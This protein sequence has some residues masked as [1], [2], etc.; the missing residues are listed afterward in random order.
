MTN[1]MLATGHREIH[2]ETK[3]SS[4][5]L[6]NEHKRVLGGAM[7]GTTIE[8]FDFFIYAQAAGLIFATQYFN[9]A[10]NQSPSLAQIIAWASLGISFLFRPVGAIIAG[11]LGDKLG[12]KPVLV[13]TL[14]G[15]GGA[16]FAM[17]LLPNYAAIGIAAPI[18][19]VLLRILQGLSAGGEWGGAALIAV[20]HAP[21]NK[22]GYFGAFPQVGVP[23]GMALATIFMLIVTTA[24]SPEQFETWGWRIP[25]LSSLLLIGI[26]FWIRSL[27]EESPV[28]AEMNDLKKTASAPL[29]TL[30]KQ[31]SKLVILC[32]LI[33]AGC[34]AAGYLAIAFFASYGTSVLKMDRP[35]VLAL[36]LLTA[37]AWIVATLVA[38]KVSDVIGRKQTF[39]IG[40]AAMII[41]AI[42]TWL[43][44]DTGNVLLFGIGVIV[45]GLFLGIT[46]GP[47]PSLY[48]EMFP[49]SVRLSGLSI[50]YA[51]GSIIGGAFAPMIA[52]LILDTTGNSINI[53]IY[54]AI[55]SAIS[56]IAVLMVP[57]GIQGKSLHD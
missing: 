52:E 35:V 55:I 53:G 33:F 21:T 10:T 48:A 57:K 24:L 16:T 49:A 42:P 32:A 18:L 31:H 13:L 38:G 9:P 17:G 27:V 34:N 39:V 26:G 50:G 23:A 7:V 43:L 28:F 45:L 12:R 47:Q 54:I 14:L 6:S 30:F 22:R 3:K 56:L 4:D 8:W 19:L 20:E 5:S 41:W 36:T 15:M 29:S 37:L 2:I 25:F 40:Y 46:Y 1:D 51:L 11:H 44:I